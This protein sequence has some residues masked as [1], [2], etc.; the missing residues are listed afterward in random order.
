MTATTITHHVISPMRAWITGTVLRVTVYFYLS[1][2]LYGGADVIGYYFVGLKFSFPLAARLA[3]EQDLPMPSVLVVTS[4]NAAADVLTKSVM[5]SC[6]SVASPVLEELTT[7]V[8]IAAF[9]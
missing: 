3:S 2:L 4:F 8:T 1:V 9:H 5:T 6:L 7:S